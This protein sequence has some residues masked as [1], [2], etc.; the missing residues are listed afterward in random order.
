MLKEVKSLYSNLLVAGLALV[1]ALPGLL[2][3]VAGVTLV[4]NLLYKTAMLVWF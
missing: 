1:I 4:V 3:M 2:L